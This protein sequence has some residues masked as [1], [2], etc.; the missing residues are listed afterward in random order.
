MKDKVIVI[1]PTS[2]MFN[3]ANEIKKFNNELTINLYH[4]PKRKL[5][6][7]SVTITSYGVLRL[8]QK[9]LNKKTWDIAVL[10]EAQNIK[11]P[12]SQSARAAFALKSN[13]RIALSGTPVE[14]RLEDL[15]SLFEFT[16]PGYLGPL[17]H[18]KNNFVKP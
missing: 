6:K 18:F 7:S 14:N 2:V 9:K 5:D 16:N 8:D 12:T 11:N 15:W 10:D 3:W 4:G 1:C 13:F 17:A